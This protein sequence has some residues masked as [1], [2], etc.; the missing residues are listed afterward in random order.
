MI[1][2]MK[3]LNFSAAGLRLPEVPGSSTRDVQGSGE[4]AAPCPEHRGQSEHFMVPVLEKLCPAETEWPEQHR[5]GT[6]RASTAQ[7]RSCRAAS[8]ASAMCVTLP[9]FL[10]GKKAFKE[11]TYEE[12]RENTPSST[13]AVEPPS[14]PKRCPTAWE[15]FRMR[16]TKLH[17]RALLLQ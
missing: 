3:D 4:G 7:P 5:A 9:I 14:C 8:P 13:A 1:L 6:S 15:G 2:K 10:G 12:H 17:A 16:R 11:L